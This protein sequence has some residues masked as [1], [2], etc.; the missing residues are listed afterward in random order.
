[1]S[2]SNVPTMRLVVDWASFNRVLTSLEHALEFSPDI[3][4][5]FLS[6]I[7]SMSQLIRVDT[8]H[9]AA[10]G[11]SEVRVSFEP[12]DLLTDFLAAFSA[13]NIK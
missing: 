6:G 8:C 4:Q 5:S 12:T 9:C 10:S 2:D 3:V 13:R 1:M 11:A 7:D